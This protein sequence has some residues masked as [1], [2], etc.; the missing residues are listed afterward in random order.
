MDT[1]TNKVCHTAAGVGMKGRVPAD[2]F[3]SWTIQLH[4]RR[5][6][7]VRSIRIVQ[8]HSPFVKF[9]TYSMFIP[10]ACVASICT[11][12]DFMALSRRIL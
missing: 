6:L 1:N 4:V 9:C 10:T 2:I 3:H 11:S 12:D 7:S 8:C 5:F